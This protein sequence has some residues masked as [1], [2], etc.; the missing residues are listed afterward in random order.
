M[1]EKIVDIFYGI[2]A[3]LILLIPMFLVILGL[4]GLN[5]ISDNTMND[6]NQKATYKAVYVHN[7]NEIIVPA[8]DC[9]SS[10][11]TKYC[12]IYVGGIIKAHTKE[13]VVQDY[14]EVE[15]DNE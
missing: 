12:T 10:S 3:V 7:K 9:K 6:W 14:W 4:I 11:N 15:A 1:K 2:I 5:T 13:Q 8:I